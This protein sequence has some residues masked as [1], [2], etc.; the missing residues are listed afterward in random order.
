MSKEDQNRQ[1]E[2]PKGMVRK[3]RRVKKGRR[4]S[5]PSS[6]RT[7][8]DAKTLFSKAKDLLIG[9]HQEDE[10]FGPIDVAEQVR[11]LKK[12]KEDSRPLDDVWGTK[13]R[14]MSWLWIV[15]VAAIISVVAIV[16]GVATW[17]GDEDAEDAGV[18]VVKDDGY[19]LEEI[20]LSEGPLGWYN[21]NSVEVIAEIR[22]I[23]DTINKAKDP[24]EIEDFVR[25]SPFRD[26]NPVTLAGFD[27]PM[28]TNVLSKFKCSQHVVYSS[29]ISGSK[30]RG[31]LEVN[32]V[33]EN[34]SPY[35]AFFTIEDQKLKI[36]WDATFGWSEMPVPELKT[37]KPK[38]SM[39]VRCR[40]TKRAS[41]DQMF[42]D[43]NYSGYVLSGETPDQFIFGYVDLDSARGKVIDRDMRLLLNYGSF[44]TDKPPKENAR[45][46]VR[47]AF[48]ESVGEKGIFE[49]VEYLHDG[50]VTP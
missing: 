35:I 40:V 1:E 43:T 49:I 41:Y 48:R 26:L 6:E 30:E 31:F 23:I 19:K 28:R 50:W 34:W 3:I 9:M 18:V 12:Q 29:E 47:V 10:D 38:K 7:K 5:R 2:V 14:S 44:V 37:Q 39:L 25:S 45:G 20:D 33:R 13:R 15:L 17:A 36:D 8:E 21:Q 4:S 32:G 16:I 11:R 24:K 42:G 27:S 22:R 46:T